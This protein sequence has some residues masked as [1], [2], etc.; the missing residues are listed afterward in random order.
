[1]IFFLVLTEYK[2]GAVPQGLRE[3]LPLIELTVSL[4]TLHAHTFA[5]S[6][7]AEDY[8]KCNEFNRQEVVTV[9]DGGQPGV[10]ELTGGSGPRRS[11]S[12]GR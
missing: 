10:E 4:G 1:M 9:C 12:T 7:K 5:K 6:Y 8:P 3:A 2:P 11:S